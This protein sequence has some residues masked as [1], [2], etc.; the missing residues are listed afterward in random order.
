MS[1]FNRNQG[2]VA[3]TRYAITKAQEQKTPTSGQ[4]MTHRERR[5]YQGQRTNDNRVQRF[6][7]G[8]LDVARKNRDISQHAGAAS[9]RA[10]QAAYRQTLAAYLLA[11][12]QLRQAVET[13]SLP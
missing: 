5:A 1:L 13:G 8:G 7:H 2:E 9:F 11:F 6:R 3:R 10:T 4:V 12:G